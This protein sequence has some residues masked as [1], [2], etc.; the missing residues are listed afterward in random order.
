MVYIPVPYGI[1]FLGNFCALSP[2]SLSMVSRVGLGGG[3]G[4]LSGSYSLIVWCFH[5]ILE[6][7]KGDF[8]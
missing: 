1:Y 5:Y 3:G 7:P 6:S 8:N 4:E 2:R